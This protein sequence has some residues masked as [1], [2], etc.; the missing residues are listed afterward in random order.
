MPVATAHVSVAAALLDTRCHKI[1]KCFYTVGYMVTDI[2]NRLPQLSSEH[3][4][5]A[6]QVTHE[7]NHTT[8]EAERTTLRK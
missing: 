3:K 6:Q 2:L 7:P 5:H 1:S 4:G 8:T